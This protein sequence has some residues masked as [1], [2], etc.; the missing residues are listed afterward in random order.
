MFK[1]QTCQSPQQHNVQAPEMSIAPIPQCSS[2]RHLNCGNVTMF[3]SQIGGLALNRRKWPEMDPDWSPGPENRS[4]GFPRPF[5]RLWDRSRGPKP[6]KYSPNSRSTAPGGRY[7]LIMVWWHSAPFGPSEPCFAP[8]G[9]YG[10]RQIARLFRIDAQLM[11]GPPGHAA[12]SPRAL[13]GP[14]GP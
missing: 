10:A 13:R 12:A 5:S 2:L 11:F 4:S 8:T 14:V 6:P 1:S 7:L 9:P 3:K